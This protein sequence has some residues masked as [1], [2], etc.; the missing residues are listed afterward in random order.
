MTDWHG[1][2]YYSLDAYCKNTYQ[3]KLYKI[4]LNAHLTCPNRDGTLGLR[5][6]IFCSAGGSG[7]FAASLLPEA[8]EGISS[9]SERSGRQRSNHSDAW[10]IDRQLRQGLAL[11][12]EKKIGEE[13]IAYFQAFTNTYGPLPYLE[14][15]Y[16]SAL[17]HPKVRGI[18][19]ATRPDCLD[20]PV[21]QLLRSLREEFPEKF[22]WI[23][24]GLQSIHEKTAKY[25]RR[26]YPLKTFEDAYARLSAAGFS[27]I[28]HLILGLPKE[29]QE[30]MLQSVEWVSRLHPFGI[31]LQLLHVLRGTDL[32][33]E[34]LAGK[35]ETLTKEAY[36]SLLSECIARLDPEIVIH[37][38]TGDGKGTDLIAPDWS[39]N[40]KDVL[41]SLHHL[42]KKKNIRQGCHCEDKP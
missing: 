7:E 19:I 34:Y 12:G 24:L 42:L 13:Y 36:L 3:H 27:V 8:E 9:N 17:S 14:N 30:E 21:I 35:F 31:K 39:K 28:I 33:T 1:K 15:I 37:R 11:F 4:A 20:A 10:D 18:S 5:G 38:V 26:G 2:P 23:E 16:R 25:I 41:N 22:I 32:E 40:K 6:C 29:S